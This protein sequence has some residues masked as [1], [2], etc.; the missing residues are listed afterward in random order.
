MIPVIL[1]LVR[2]FSMGPLVCD[3][4]ILPI[5]K[6]PLSVGPDYQNAN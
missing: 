4:L 1:I 6:R 2:G 3:F 5:S